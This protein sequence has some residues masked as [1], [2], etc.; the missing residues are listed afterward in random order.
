MQPS[1]Q[2]NSKFSK[3]KKVIFG[4]KLNNEEA[5]R[6]QIKS[7]RQ[8]KALSICSY[9]NIKFAPL[10]KPES[11]SDITNYD[12]SIIDN[13]FKSSILRLRDENEEDD[14]KKNDEEI[15]ATSTP[16]NDHSN[17]EIQNLCLENS[18]HVNTSELNCTSLSVFNRQMNFSN[19]ESNSEKNFNNCE[20]L[21]FSVST[22]SKITNNI[23][24][25]TDEADFSSLE[26]L[27]ILKPQSKDY[28]LCFNNSVDSSIK[29]NK[30]NEHMM[31]SE[32]RIFEQDFDSGIDIRNVTESIHLNLK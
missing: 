18:N 14:V 21:T 1:N 32:E 8:S 17:S 25:Q 5:N 30:T 9:E 28:I 24:F 23:S 11:M 12:T 4:H 27:E 26:K 19:I 15:A 2:I 29:S 20:N 10:A 31:I 22:D 6:Q 13:S 3:L 7:N 16:R